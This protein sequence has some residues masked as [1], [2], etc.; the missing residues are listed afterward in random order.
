[1]AIL[2]SA[3]IISMSVFD[4][5]IQN[6]LRSFAESR[7]VIEQNVPRLHGKDTSAL[8]LPRTVFKFRRYPG[9]NQ[10]WIPSLF[11]YDH[12]F[13]V[14]NPKYITEVNLTLL[15]LFC[16]HYKLQVLF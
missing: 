6:I 8:L 3:L 1:M 2:E 16:F 13:F 9:T 5:T 10:N 4:L 14:L 15:V 11:Q 12:A 7:S